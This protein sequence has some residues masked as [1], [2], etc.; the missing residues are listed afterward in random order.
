MMGDRAASWPR[1]CRCH[2]PKNIYPLP[3]ELLD[4]NSEESRDFSR[5][6]TSTRAPNAPW[7]I[8]GTPGQFFAV[9]GRD[10]I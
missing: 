9:W 6:S 7:A 3:G 1:T 5:G 4:T 10:L 8:L 2:D